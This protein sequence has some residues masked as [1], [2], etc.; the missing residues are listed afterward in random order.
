MS[1][2]QRSSL[3]GKHQRTPPRA[4]A[5][6]IVYG[7]SAVGLPTLFY[8]EV[9]ES[10]VVQVLPPVEEEP[11]TQRG[12]TCESAE[13]GPLLET[14]KVGKALLSDTANVM[15]WKRWVA[16]PRTQILLELGHS[17]AS[18]EFWGSLL[19]SSPKRFPSI[20]ASWKAWF[21]CELVSNSLCI[22]YH[23]VVSLPATS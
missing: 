11:R 23:L 9:I 4:L 10:L 14:S 19:G 3:S 2:R 1:P 17:G 22:V 21:W 6:Y 12:R 8:L 5:E 13:N 18:C 15:F 20:W 7:L 16:N